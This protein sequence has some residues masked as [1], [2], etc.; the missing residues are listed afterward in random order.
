[1][2]RADELIAM[3]HRQLLENKLVYETQQAQAA[4]G[5]YH[6]ALANGDEVSAEAAID[7][8]ASRV[9]A[10][11]DISEALGAGQEQQQRGGKPNDGLHDVERAW[12]ASNPDYL[13][14]PQKQA[15]LASYA[16]ALIASGLQ[17][18]S[19]EML[20][21]VNNKFGPGDALPS[22]AEAAKIAGI[23]LEEWERQNQRLQVLK[24][25]G[26]YGE[27]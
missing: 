1:M 12:L 27:R 24:R 19:K 6:A 17:R 14:D 7:N 5:D 2:P 22:H 23:S 21:A 3:R 13:S 15:Q 25:Q 8:Y 18:G 9:R 4:A 11:N 16:N 10:V 20:D 26:Q